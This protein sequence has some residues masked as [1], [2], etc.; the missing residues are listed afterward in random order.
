MERKLLNRIRVVLAEK[1]MSN[2]HLAELLG[3]DPAVVSKW[4]TNTNQPSLETLIAIANALEVP[5]Q[6]LVRQE[7]FN[8]EK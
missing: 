5:V 8:Q 2:K 6:E 4:V 7:E 1:D 3:K